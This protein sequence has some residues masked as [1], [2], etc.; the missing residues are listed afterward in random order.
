MIGPELARW[1]EFAMLARIAML[2]AMTVVP[3][4]LAVFM[5]PE[6]TKAAPT[7]LAGMT[8]RGDEFVNSI[9]MKLA[10]IPIGTFLMGSP[11]DEKY[12]EDSEQHEVEITRPFYLGFHEVTQ[13]QFEKVMGYNPSFF[14]RDG[15]GRSGLEYEEGEPA[16]GKE[17]VADKDTRDFPV[18]NVSWEEAVEFCARLSARPVEKTAG[19]KYRLPTEAEWEYAGRGGAPAYQVFHFGNSLSSTQANFVGSHP[20]GGAA[21]GPYLG[22]TCK[23]GSFKPNAFGL[24]DMHGNVWEWCNDWYDKDYYRKGPRR[25]P[26]GAVEGECRVIR[27]GSW[28]DVS[29]CCRSG[30]RGNDWPHYCTPF[31]GFRV[32]M[33][34]SRW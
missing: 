21:E 2:T 10:R 32:A 8:R 24:F 5:A 1:K 11:K 26:N 25:D 33:T 15:Q 16:G 4:I 6:A 28:D 13:G 9:G 23:V 3:G 29:E 18:E 22:R 31:V 12:H 27:G 7:P 14:S 19:R 17:R 30:R 20:Y 34:P